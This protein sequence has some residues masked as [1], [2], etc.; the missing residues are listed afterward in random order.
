MKL[1][2]AIA[3]VL[4]REG[5]SLTVEEITERI[6]A[7]NL[8]RRKDNQPLAAGQVMLRLKG[9]LDKFSICVTFKES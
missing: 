8:Y 3:V 1:H 2:E 6:N 9:H 5:K 4:K 7:E